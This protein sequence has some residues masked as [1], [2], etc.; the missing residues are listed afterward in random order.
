MKNILLIT[1][2]LVLLS[3][4]RESNE[5]AVTMD[6]KVILKINQAATE[7]VERKKI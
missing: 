4:C 2:A 1:A 5:E 7:Y 6:S 3:G